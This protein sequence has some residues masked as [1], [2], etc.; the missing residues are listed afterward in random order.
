MNDFAGVPLFKAN[1]PYKRQHFHEK[2]CSRNPR[3]DKYP[4][5]VRLQ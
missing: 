1:L 2:I 4:N 5:Y 3:D